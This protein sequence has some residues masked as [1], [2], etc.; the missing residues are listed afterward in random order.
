MR[1][2]QISPARRSLSPPNGMHAIRVDLTDPGYQTGYSARIS[3]YEQGIRETAGYTVTQFLRTNRV[4]IAINANYFTRAC[5]IYSPRNAKVVSG[6]LIT[7]SVRV[8]PA[9]SEH[10]RPFIRRLQLSHR[11]SYE[12]PGAQHR[13]SKDAVTGTYPS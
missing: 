2:A 12:L 5:R 1:S 11:L 6:M 9:N 8:S 13:G 4:Q 10:S 7:D 3:G